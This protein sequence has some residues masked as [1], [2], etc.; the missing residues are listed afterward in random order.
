MSHI[1]KTPFVQSLQQRTKP[2]PQYTLKSLP[3]VGTEEKCIMGSAR[4]S[5]AAVQEAGRVANAGC[6]RM[7]HDWRV[8]A[9]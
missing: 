1:L 5:P 2:A 6:A 4:C 9:E 7:K 3:C 8:L